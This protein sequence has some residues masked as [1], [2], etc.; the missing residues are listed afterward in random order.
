MSRLLKG[1]GSQRY[2]SIADSLS[3]R[4]ESKTTNAAY[5]MEN[6]LNRLSCIKAKHDHRCTTTLKKKGKENGKH[7]NEHLHNQNTSVTLVPAPIV[8]NTIHT[9]HTIFVPA[10][11][12]I[13]QQVSHFFQNQSNPSIHLLGRPVSAPKA[14]FNYISPCMPNSPNKTLPLSQPSQVSILR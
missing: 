13:V 4:Y 5:S 3:K 10:P 11:P 1:S 12:I 7:I 14:T 6:C 8:T 9:I 2:R